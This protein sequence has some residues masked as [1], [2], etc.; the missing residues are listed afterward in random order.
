MCY[1]QITSSGFFYRIHLNEILKGIHR[2]YFGGQGEGEQLTFYK[3]QAF[4]LKQKETN[5]LKLLICEV[6]S[7]L[8]NK[9]SDCEKRTVRRSS[10]EASV[11]LHHG[12][13]QDTEAQFFSL[14]LWA[15]ISVHLVKS[16]AVQLHAGAS[17]S[18][19]FT[20]SLSCPVHQSKNLVD[21]TRGLMGVC[22]SM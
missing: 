5:V 20:S 17:I 12:P 2:F 14:D 15:F 4:H 21:F 18:A 8:G 10:R 11:H 6:F 16:S 3:C 22:L 7:A 9:F 1:G 13:I 19:V